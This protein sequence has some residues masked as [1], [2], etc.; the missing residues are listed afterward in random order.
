MP[1][2]SYLESTFHR[3]VQTRLGGTTHKLLPAVDSGIPDRLVVLPGGIL[4]LVELKAEDGRLRPDQE[5]WHR[6]AAKRGVRVSVVSSREG[7]DE[8]ISERNTS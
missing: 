1:R 3:L 6:K 5:L 2:E 8:W 7:I 4:E